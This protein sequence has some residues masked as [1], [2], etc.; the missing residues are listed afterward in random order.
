[1]KSIL[2]EDW[3]RV[4][5]HNELRKT[6]REPPLI[7]YR[8]SP[9]L[10]QLLTRAKLNHTIQIDLPYHPAPIIQSISFPAKN[11]KCRHLQCGTCPQL[12]EKS[13]YTSYQTKHYF[14]INDIYSCD[15]T[16]AIY[17]LE[18]TLCH[19]Q[20]IGETHTTVRSRMVHHRNMQKNCHQ[21]TYLCPY[22]K[23]PQEL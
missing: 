23:P 5:S 15:T 16:H 1:M 17:L 19:K 11:I 13:H 18:C 2:E 22:S 12:S 7:S 14:Q 9:N 21:Q 4:T 20:Y 3:P 6:Y 8:H 10:A